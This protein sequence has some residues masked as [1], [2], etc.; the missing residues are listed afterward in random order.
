MSRRTQI[1]YGPGTLDCDSLLPEPTNQKIPYPS[2]LGTV[3]RYF[4]VRYPR[5]KLIVSY[6]WQVRN[7][8]VLTI[9]VNGHRGCNRRCISLNISTLS[10]S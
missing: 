3:C 6:I 9:F 7:T 10:L 5:N 2:P 1:A 4:Q 8:D